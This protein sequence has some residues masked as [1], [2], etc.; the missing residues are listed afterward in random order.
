MI[1]FLNSLALLLQAMQSVGGVD[2]QIS[3]YR[4]RQ[5]EGY[6]DREKP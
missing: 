6:T 3:C 4:E 2:G 5:R 1:N